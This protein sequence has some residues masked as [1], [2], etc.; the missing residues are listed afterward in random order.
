MGEV[1]VT[2]C[3]FCVSI[4]VV[5]VDQVTDGLSSTAQLNI[6]ILDYNDNSPQFPSIPDPLMIIEGDYSVE[7]PGEIFT[8]TPT[9][10]DLGLNGE[11]TLS[12]IS[13]HPV[14][15]FREVRQKGKNSWEHFPTCQ[16]STFC[17]L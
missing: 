7:S 8:I 10:A 14:F 16:N 17:L 13:P 12:L 6:T 5:A 11:V 1:S 3:V 2:F 9:D 4:Q 15:R